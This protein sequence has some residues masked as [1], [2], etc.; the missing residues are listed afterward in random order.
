MQGNIQLLK[1]KDEMA[2]YLKDILCK[3]D[4]CK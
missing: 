4:I 1:I 2:T 3:T